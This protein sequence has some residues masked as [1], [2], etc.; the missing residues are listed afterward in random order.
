MMWAFVSLAMA[1]QLPDRFNGQVMRP[2]IDAQKTLWAEQS[3]TAPDGYATFRVYTQYANG[4]VRDRSTAVTQRLVDDLLEFDLLGAWHW[5]GLRLGAHIPIYGLTTGDDA[6]TQPG[7]GDI[8]FDVKATVLEGETDPFGAAI[9]ARMLLPTTSVQIPLGSTGLGSEIFVAADRDIDQFTLVT[10]LGVRI[11]PQAR[12]GDIGWDDQFFGRVAVALSGDR[13]GGS[14][15]G[16]LQTNFASAENPAGTAAE[17]LLAGHAK[18][19]DLWTLRGGAST[20]LSTSPGSPLFRVLAGISYEPDPS[21]DNDRDGLV[22]RE[23][24]CPRDAEDPDGYEDYDGC[25]DASYSVQVMVTDPDG[26]P[27]EA[28]VVLDGV[29]SHHLDLGDRVATVHPGLYRLIAKVDGY[30]SY[31][32]EVDIPAVQGHQVKVEVSPRQ[33]QVR[34]WAVDEVGNRVAARFT[35]DGLDSQPTGGEPVT[36]RT[37]EHAIVVTADGYR[38]APVSVNVAHGQTRALSVVLDRLPA[39]PSSRDDDE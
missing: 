39:A 18:L 15:E 36:V 3:A 20:G 21:P 4:V 17:L 11:G 9:I 28:L 14:L 24:G 7:L 25:P 30:D 19:T 34:V 16:G 31:V 22:D 27:L 1:Q 6:T 8:A 35:I 12:V 33:G 29:E 26:D 32:G 13:F 38:A 10:N 5:R 2:S 23:D 37:G